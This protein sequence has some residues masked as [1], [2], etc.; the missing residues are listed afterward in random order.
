MAEKCVN[1]ILSDGNSTS[2]IIMKREEIMSR[3]T[4]NRDDDADDDTDHDNDTDDDDKLFSYKYI[5]SLHYDSVKK[6]GLLGM[7]ELFYNVKTFDC[8]TSKTIYSFIKLFSKN[9]TNQEH[10]N[11]I[12]LFKRIFKKSVRHSKNVLIL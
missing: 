4:S 7:Y 12:K 2:N 10:L 1:Y 5:L 11:S 6:L 8:E 9:I 3:Y